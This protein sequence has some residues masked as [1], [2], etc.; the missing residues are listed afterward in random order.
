MGIVAERRTEPDE[1][2]V[3]S[4]T[5]TGP[6]PEAAKQTSRRPVSI[7]PKVSRYGKIFVIG[8]MLL[9]LGWQVFHLII[10]LVTLD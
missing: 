4:P 3:P 10:A 8:A 6:R 7:G 2:V 9:A 1:G 5:T